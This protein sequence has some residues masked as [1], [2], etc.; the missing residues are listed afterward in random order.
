MAAELRLALQYALVPENATLFARDI[1]AQSA[2]Q[3]I[4]LDY[5]LDSLGFADSVLRSLRAN[6]VTV[7][8]VPEVLL[9][10]GCY[11]GEVVLRAREGSWRA[12]SATALPISIVLSDGT[13]FDP[14]GVAFAALAGA[15]SL[16]DYATSIV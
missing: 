15:S 7:E 16:V 11:L 8:Q 14:L 3:G 13:A 1:V 5:S 9:G 10:F 2:Q 4:Q 6:G 12:N